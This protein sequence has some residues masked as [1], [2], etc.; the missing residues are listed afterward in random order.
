M[1]EIQHMTK[2]V[3]QNTLILKSK[4]FPTIKKKLYYFK[5]DHKNYSL[6]QVL[7]V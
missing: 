1:T 3:Q 4:H 7:Q 5:R 6:F 2:K